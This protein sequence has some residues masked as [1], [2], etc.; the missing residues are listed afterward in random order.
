MSWHKDFMLLLIF[1]IYNLMYSNM[2]LKWTKYQT[3]NVSYQ[4]FEQR[5]EDINGDHY[6]FCSNVVKK[7]EISPNSL[8]FEMCRLIY[9]KDK[10]I[11]KD[12]KIIINSLTE[13]HKII[14][15]YLFK[16]VS[17][18]MDEISRYLDYSGLHN[19]SHGNTLWDGYLSNVNSGFPLQNR[20][21]KHSSD[22]MY[23]AL[24]HV[25]EVC[26]KF[27]LTCMMFYGTLL[28]S[29]RHHSIIPWDHDADIG[30]IPI[31]NTL[32]SLTKELIVEEINR[33]KQYRLSY[34]PS[35]VL[36]RVHC[37]PETCPPYY[38]IVNLDF[39]AVQG[40]RIH[41]RVG[42]LAWDIDDVLPLKHRPLGNL[43]LP[44]PQN[45]YAHLNEVYPDSGS[46][47]CH[48]YKCET[49]KDRCGFV[50]RAPLL[51][52]LL[53]VVI[54]NFTVLH[55]SLTS[56][57]VVLPPYKI[58]QQ[59][60]EELSVMLKVLELRSRHNLTVSIDKSQRQTKMDTIVQDFI[61]KK[62]N[63]I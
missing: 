19:T 5:S 10:Q 53:E 29:W 45:T 9:N 31:N 16:N 59:S 49:K 58:V 7:L 18:S 2:I 3:S 46:N 6:Y 13:L 40:T 23:K 44:S 33:R 28:G 54:K 35:G 22:V 62:S 8:S 32:L 48:P 52:F 57:N 15:R 30:I 1:V 4:H 56:D 20:S 39:L 61:K 17:K 27:N 38:H 63:S 42:N 21:H 24:E 60:P 11:L 34:D 51:N 43:V 12:E 41:E 14:A 47:D 36:I 25:N 50:Y 37:L 26:V 55:V